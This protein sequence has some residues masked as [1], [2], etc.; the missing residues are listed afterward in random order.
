MVAALDPEDY[1][2]FQV[3]RPTVSIDADGDRQITWPTTRLSWSR[4]AGREPRHRAGSRHRAQHAL[5]HVLRRA[6]RLRPRP[7]QSSWWS[8][9]V[10]CSPTC[11]TPVPIPV[12]GTASD[13]S[14]PGALALEQSR[15]EG[16]TG[17]VGVF[18]DAC[19]RRGLAR[20][21]VLGRR[22][23]LRG[24]AAVPE[25]HAGA[26]PPARGPARHRRSRWATCPRRHARGSGGST[27]WRAEDSE[28]AEYV[29][30]ARAGAG[31]RRSAGGHRRGDRPRVRALSKR[32][33]SGDS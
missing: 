30:V 19:Q 22:T 14:W 7:G 1:Y 29:A 6:A 2:D 31:H 4:L 5:A 9:W 23:A 8:R 32:R 33:R 25:G 10:R 16:P 11:R 17:I 20:G 12:T 18:Q 27:S 24:A 28:V 21:V 13:P 3:N 15:Y 26:A